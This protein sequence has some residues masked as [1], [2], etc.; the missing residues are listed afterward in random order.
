MKVERKPSNQELRTRKD[1]LLAARQLM[2]Q[3]RKPTLEQVAK[4]AMVS[5]ATA[6]RYFPNIDALL[7]EVPI[8]AAVGNP[9]EM[10]ANDPST[11]A[12]ARVDDAEASMHQVV[13]E[14]EAQLRILLANSIAH[15]AGRD[16]PPNRQGRR[17][18]LIEAAL[19]TSRRRFREEDY[20]TLCSALAMIFGPESMIVFR[21]VIRAD[22]RTAR[23]VK[24]WAVRA[25]VRAALAS[26]EP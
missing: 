12:E 25:L 23:R 6:Y 9:G 21:D 17:L 5:R 22:E 26:S 7:V 13:Y 1:L 20:E 18:A 4:A 10:F 11:D 19:A 24:S 16:A 15:G 2:T 8:D 3:G 14:N